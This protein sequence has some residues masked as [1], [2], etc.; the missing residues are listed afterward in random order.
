MLD[1]AV[2]S[3]VY[4]LL[5]EAGHSARR[6]APASYEPTEADRSWVMSILDIINRPYSAGSGAIVGAQD[7]LVGGDPADIARNAWAGLTGERYYSGSDIVGRIVDPYSEGRNDAA[8]RWGGL[9][10][11]L[12]VGAVYDPLSYLTFGSGKAATALQKATRGLKAPLAKGSLRGFTKWPGRTEAARRGASLWN[13]ARAWDDAT[14]WSLLRAKGRVPFTP[15]DIDIPLT[16]RVVN[17]PAAKGLDWAG[18]TIKGSKAYKNLRKVVGGWRYIV[19]QEYPGLS[20]FLAERRIRDRDHYEEVIQQLQS[21]V[22]KYPKQAREWATH[23]YE[24]P[25]LAN[26]SKTVKLRVP[27]LETWDDYKKFAEEIRPFVEVPATATRFHQQRVLQETAA[28][29][30]TIR[31]WHDEAGGIRTVDVAE[32]EAELF[33]GGTDLQPGELLERMIDQADPR[34]SPEELLASYLA[35]QGNLAPDAQV[36]PEFIG[37]FGQ[38][39]YQDLFARHMKPRT[40]QRVPVTERV[41]VLDPATNKPIL[42]KKGKRKGKPLL[43]TRPVYDEAGNVR[44]RTKTTGG[45]AEFRQRL[46]RIAERRASK[47]EGARLPEFASDLAGGETGNAVILYRDPG[48][49]NLAPELERIGGMGPLPTR[50]QRVMDVLDKVERWTKG[51]GNTLELSE[52]II[53][54]DQKAIDAIIKKAKLPNNKTTRTILEAVHYSIWAGNMA[55]GRYSDHA[56]MLADELMAGVTMSPHQRYAHTQRTLK[57]KRADLIQQ[58]DEILNGEWPDPGKGPPDIPD[59][60]DVGPEIWQQTLEEF[61][62]VEDGTRDVHRAAVQKAL[63]EGQVVPDEVLKA[64]RGEAWADEALGAPLDS[65]I[66]QTA[67]EGLGDQFEPDDPLGEYAEPVPTTQN[68]RLIDIEQQLEEIDEYL[69]VVDPFDKAYFTKKMLEGYTKPSFG[70]RLRVEKVAGKDLFDDAARAAYAEGAKWLDDSLE[71][72]MSRIKRIDP[73]AT[74][75]VEHYVP[76][77]F[78]KQRPLEWL[79]RRRVTKKATEEF[80]QARRT[81]WTNY[82]LKDP[83]MVEEIVNREIREH[84]GLN[85]PGWGKKTGHGKSK[86]FLPR[87]YNNTLLEMEYAGFPHPWEKDFPVV[88]NDAVRTRMNWNFGFDV[89]DYAKKHFAKHFDDLTAETIQAERLVPMNYFVPWIDDAKNPFRGW[90]IPKDLDN[91]LQGMLHL[92]HELTSDE[93]FRGILEWISA[94]RRWW[95]AWTLLPFPAFHARNLGSDMLMAAQ[96]GAKAWSR[97]G[98]KSF[99]AGTEFVF[100]DLPVAG[101][102][103]EKWDRIGKY[104]AELNKAFPDIS[105]DDLRRIMRREEIIEGG[106]R[107]VDLLMQGAQLQ[108]KEGNR[109]Q[110]AL[111]EAKYWIPGK[112]NI[113]ES[114]L[115]AKTGRVGQRTQDA[116]RASTFLDILLQNSKIPGLQWDDALD[117]ALK[118]TRKAL[119]DYH[120]LTA[121]ER[122]LMKNLFPFYTFTAKNIP[123]QLEVLFTEPKRFAHLARAYNGLWNTDDEIFTREQ[124]PYWL[125]N[126]MG[127]PIRRKSVDGFEQWVVWSPTGWIPMTEIN[128]L[129]E[130]FRGPFKKGDQQFEETGK[131]WLSRLNPMFKEPVEQLMNYDSFTGRKIDQGEIRDVFGVSVHPRIAHALRNIRLVTELDRL[132]PGGVFTELGKVRGHWKDERPHRREAPGIYRGIRFGVGTSLYNQRPLK[133]MRNKSIR[134]QI[135]ANKLEREARRSYMRGQVLEAERLRERAE[136]KQRGLVALRQQIERYR[137][138]RAREVEQQEKRKVGARP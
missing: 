117:D 25:E 104:V 8:K 93:A 121:T 50:Q 47:S 49:S 44:M 2:Q 138:G 15:W 68:E 52:A 14:Q 53:A 39:E 89:Y 72:M 28:L 91:T 115:L 102:H 30:E 27:K 55:P 113:S 67:R 119:F 45:A 97:T 103:F 111:Q 100:G 35:A 7:A 5:E 60:D 80:A 114:K 126:A 137:Q 61:E 131:F 107:D 134:L 90:Y 48:Y 64:Y 110:R 96:F 58:R 31:N 94:V 76:H 12:S 11:D 88:I 128:E 74:P 108:I 133:E 33:R 118:V 19:D 83:D 70:K 23:I 78:K 73:N 66:E 101:K 98:R 9:A 129:A 105:A 1:P 99:P 59:V 26:V 81:F 24:M 127:V 40:K 42:V 46:K 10:W 136:D 106:M 34:F 86:S 122:H 16:P 65:P 71:D 84:F 22:D 57:Q 132:N 120:D 6:A 123:K 125:K 13:P 79:R 92:Q 36:L 77:G 17:V 75:P 87:K 21:M 32:L 63:N 54:G 3:R 82:G 109:A 85:V 62:F 38:D 43:T 18:E 29:R 112:L 41:P 20:S 130:M 116:V 4:E 69:N 56:G 95:S 124:L 135:E 51:G 37:I